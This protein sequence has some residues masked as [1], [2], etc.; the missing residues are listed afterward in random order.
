M[1]LPFLYAETFVFRAYGG[2]FGYLSGSGIY[3]IAVIYELY[4]YYFLCSADCKYQ[5]ARPQKGDNH[6]NE[7]SIGGMEQGLP[8]LQ[9]RT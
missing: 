6:G 9:H 4:I 1:D 5:Q 7:K 2:D 8:R 3:E